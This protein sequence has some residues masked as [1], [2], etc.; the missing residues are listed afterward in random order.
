MHYATDELSITAAA[1]SLMIY[2][3][4][5][6]RLSGQSATVWGQGGLAKVFSTQ[7]AKQVYKFKSHRVDK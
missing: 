6:W 4:Y 5:C 7:K 1:V 3:T 2:P